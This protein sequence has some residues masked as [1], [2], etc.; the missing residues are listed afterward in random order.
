MMQAYRGACAIAPQ[1][2][3][4]RLAKGPCVPLAVK[5]TSIMRSRRL[6]LLASLV[7]YLALM[8]SS[9]QA[10]SAGPATKQTPAGSSPVLDTQQL[11]TR[12]DQ[13]IAARW[14][15]K[16][17]QPAPR[18]DDA[19]YFRRVSLDLAGRIPRALEVREFLDDKAADKR[20]RVVE[21][22]LDDPDYVHHYINHFTNVWRALLVAQT[23]NQQVQFLLP[24][25]EA[26]L[27]QRV[28]SNT[29]YDEVVRE[30]LTASVSFAA[31]NPGQ[32]RNP[33]EPSPLAFYQANDL[34]PENLAASTTRLLLGVK[35]EC[36]QCHDHPHDHWTRKQFWEYA[37]F[38]SGLRADNMGDFITAVREDPQ[39]RSIKIPGKEQ[40][41]NARFLDGS[42]PTW[43]AETRARTALAQW[44]TDARN[45]YFAREA[46]NR[47]WAHFFGIGLIEPVDEI[48]DD[49]PPSHPELLD[50][51]ARQFIAHKFD[52][53]F[54]IRAIT[55]S[56]TYQRSSATTDRSQ[57]DPRLFARMAVKGL[58]PEQFFDSV[59]E[60]TGFWQESRP[61]PRL[62]GQALNT[63]RAM[64]LAKFSTPDKRTEAQTS[65]L[66]ALA[67]MN[68]KFIDDATSI[69]RSKTLA[70]VVDAP[71][72]NTAQRIETLYFTT[73][74]RKPRA[75]ELH[76]LVK[77]VTRGGPRGNERD[78]LAD[79]FWALLNSGEFMFNH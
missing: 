2:L 64:F 6:W 17:V 10:E 76:R 42:E 65:I 52:V 60:A 43:Q 72:L 13:L 53:K 4:V 56:E 5:E 9:P 32:L 20:Q 69:E 38:F 37:A 54:L 59:A 51:L 23:N 18:A 48:S 14:A 49:N 61:T 26:W 39:G 40:I 31:R 62:D 57:D 35:L 3:P 78:A 67:L 15:A 74:S 75:D 41:V 55:R 29:P 46:A 63:P 68:G 34:K 27:R 8:P 45:P 28:R 58:S 11:A 66:Q 44:I 79:V 70:A 36:A 25:F 24:S 12:I 21:R 47:L 22:L 73:L 50:E 19:E 33:R 7:V 30:L 1:L 71:F 16:G 77:Y